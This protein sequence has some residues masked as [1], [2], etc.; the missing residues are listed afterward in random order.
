MNQFL[1]A[2]HAED[3]APSGCGPQ[4]RWLCLLPRNRVVAGQRSNIAAAERGHP[5][6]AR[7]AQIGTCFAW[8]RRKRF[9]RNA[10]YCRC[11]SRSSFPVALQLSQKR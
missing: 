9:V 4:A 6:H 8:S 5:E 10:R 1:F 2:K 7:R 11:G 3:R